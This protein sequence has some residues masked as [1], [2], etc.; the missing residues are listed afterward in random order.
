MGCS[1]GCQLRKEQPKVMVELI[2]QVSRSAENR[3]SGSVRSGWDSELHHFS[4]TLELMRVFEDLVPF[5]PE[6]GLPLSSGASAQPA[7]P[8]ASESPKPKTP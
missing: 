4:G 6:A 5:V 2:L 3:L 1:L 8:E 7:Q